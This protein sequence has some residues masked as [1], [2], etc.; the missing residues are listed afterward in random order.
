MFE[1]F[2]FETFIYRAPFEEVKDDI[3]QA[4]R[5]WNGLKVMQLLSFLTQALLLQTAENSVH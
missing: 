1:T 4:K 5:A 2:I 3:F